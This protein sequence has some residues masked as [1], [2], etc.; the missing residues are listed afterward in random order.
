[1]RVAILSESDFD[2]SVARILVDAVIGPTEAFPVPLR[3]RGGWTVVRANAPW[4]ARQLH[5][6]GADGLVVIAD[7]DLSE[8]SPNFVRRDDVSS[9][10]G[11]AL[12]DLPPR[13][14]LP[15]LRTAVGIAVPAIEARLLAG[16]GDRDVGEPG[17][18]A[19]GRSPD[20][21]ELKRR[22]YGQDRAPSSVRRERG[23]DAARLLAATLD[24]VQQRFPAGLGAL[25]ADLRAWT[26]QT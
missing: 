13:A 12:R 23:L 21:A 4:I 11:D 8:V 25:C 7:S 26:P 24:R 22:L 16:A 20:G 18:A 15:P 10:I 2:E 5:F 6:A 3:T 1:M 17:I 19:R 9:A 14:G